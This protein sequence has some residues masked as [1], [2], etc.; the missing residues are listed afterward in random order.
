MTVSTV[1]NQTRVFLQY[2]GNTPPFALYT[3]IRYPRH[4]IAHVFKSV[5]EQY[6]ITNVCSAAELNSNSK[7]NPLIAAGVFS[8]VEVPGTDIQGS[9]Y[10]NPAMI[11]ANVSGLGIEATQRYILTAGTGGTADDHTI[12]LPFAARVTGLKGLVSTTASGGNIQLFSAASGAGSALSGTLSTTTAGVV[13]EAST[14]YTTTVALAA[15]ASIYIHRT[16]NTAA[17]EL[18]ISLLVGA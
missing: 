13:T 5:G 7:I 11:A 3:M 6:D 16:N 9:G 14:S 1:Q 10:V 18:V 4:F 8:V 12:V 17:A 2:N 15:G